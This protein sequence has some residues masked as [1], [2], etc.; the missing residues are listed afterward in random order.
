MYTI[1]IETS[2]HIIA[3]ISL[4]VSVVN[5]RKTY[6][7]SKYM[8]VKK[9]KRKINIILRTKKTKLIFYCYIKH[10]LEIKFAVF[11]KWNW[12]ER[13]NVICLVFVYAHPPS[14]YKI[15]IRLHNLQVEGLH[16]NTKPDINW[17]WKTHYW[18]TVII[19]TSTEISPWMRK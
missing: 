13:D 4:E 19:R 18:T 5:F 14:H 2:G 11:G 9:S 16:L 15:Q 8:L 7:V 1:C 3:C 17:K 10:I 6:A 12:T